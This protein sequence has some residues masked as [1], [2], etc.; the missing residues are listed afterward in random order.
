MTAIDKKAARAA[1]REHKSIA[2]IYAV[3]CGAT[4]QIWVGH[5]PTLDAVQN[6]LWFTLRQ[7]GHPD[8]ALQRAWNEQSG[9]GFAFEELERVKDDDLSFTGDGALKERAAAWRQKLGALAVI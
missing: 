1:Y 6:R 9:A 3:R 5:T 8:A 2:G 4:G 7:K